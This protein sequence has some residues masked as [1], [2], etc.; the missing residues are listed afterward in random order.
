MAY[1]EEKN[2]QLSGHIDYYKMKD[3]KYNNR[4][5]WLRQSKAQ[6]VEDAQC[7]IKKQQRGLDEAK[8]SIKYL[9]IA[10]KKKE[11]QLVMW[12]QDFKAVRE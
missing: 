8:D 6:A 9:R 2:I 3:S 1:L 12:I 4:A 5:K 11:E 10:N 7:T